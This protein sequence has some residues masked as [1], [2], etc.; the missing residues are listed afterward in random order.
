MLWFSLERLCLSQ[1]VSVLSYTL[2][3]ASSLF[4]SVQPL[5][6][7][8]GNRG[9]G[10]EITFQLA[11]FNPANI[12]IGSRNKE[13]GETAMAEITASMPNVRVS[14]IQLDLAS[15]S[16]VKLAATQFLA[17]NSRLDILINNAGIMAVPEGLTADGYEIQFGTNTIG[18]ALLT[19]L[20]LP[21]M[22][23]TAEEPGSD[24]RVVTLSSGSHNR[25]PKGGV[26][27]ETLHNASSAGSGLGRYGQS[28]LGNILYSKELARRYPSITA[29]SVHPG[30]VDTDLTASML[31]HSFIMR[32]IFPVARRIIGVVTIEQGALNPVWAATAAEVESGTYYEPVG[33]KSS[34]SK[35]SR[36]MALAQKLW[37][38]VEKELA[39]Y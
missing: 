13:N 24:V 26:L 27:F 23:K 37:E 22:L 2:C 30:V 20:L 8:K 33:K 7:T 35:L 18:H 12:F 1:G 32:I 17:T 38:W 25:A 19:K 14:V 28:K 5:M 34:G 16:S 21:I 39:S 10:K 31:K 6:L 3:C 29:V 15:L 4:G 11:K 9:L 36:D